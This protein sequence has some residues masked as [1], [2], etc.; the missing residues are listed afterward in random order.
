MVVPSPSWRFCLLRFHGTLSPWRHWPKYIAITPTASGIFEPKQLPQ[1][2]THP[3][4]Y[5]LLGSFQDSGFCPAHKCKIRHAVNNIVSNKTPS[6]WHPFIEDL[7]GELCPRGG[8]AT[9][10]DKADADA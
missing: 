1:S 6:Q 8:N 7:I 3:R 5:I 2:R 10:M 4:F 9:S